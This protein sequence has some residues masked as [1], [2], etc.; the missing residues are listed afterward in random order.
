MRHI[1]RCGV[2][3]YVYIPYKFMCLSKKLVDVLYCMD[4]VG[5]DLHVR[6]AIPSVSRVDFKLSIFNDFQALR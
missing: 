2:D 4:P 5:F 1:N 6:E 3:L